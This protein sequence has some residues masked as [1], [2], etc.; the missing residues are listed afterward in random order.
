[1]FNKI[2]LPKNLEVVLDKDH[3][4]KHKGFKLRN[5]FYQTPGYLVR[6]DIDEFNGSLQNIIFIGSK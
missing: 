3:F 6:Y 2:D 1:M 5:D 4:E